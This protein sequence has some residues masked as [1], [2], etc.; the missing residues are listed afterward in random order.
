MFLGSNFIQV[1]HI[2]LQKNRA[3]V[4]ISKCL[5]IKWC[6][7]SSASFKFRYVLFF[8]LMTPLGIAIGTIITELFSRPE[9]DSEV[10]TNDT[11]VAVLQT[12]ASGTLLYVAFFEVRLH[13]LELIFFFRFIF[14]HVLIIFSRL[15]LEKG[16]DSPGRDCFSS[17]LSY[18]AGWLWSW[19]KFSLEVMITPFLV[20]DM[21]TRTVQL[22]TTRLPRLPLLLFFQ[23]LQITQLFK[24]VSHHVVTNISPLL[25]PTVFLHIEK[26]I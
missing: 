17:S 20:M 16:Q 26:S 12:L 10:R 3:R 11:L 23:L 13:E 14:R 8:A 25:T 24:S 2:N 19:W 22:S 9:L 15:F 21:V 18:W 7:N 5:I 1:E 4:V 6:F